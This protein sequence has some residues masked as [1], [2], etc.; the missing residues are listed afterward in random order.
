[1]IDAFGS[2]EFARVRVGI[3]RP[4]TKEEVTGYV[5]SQ[6][7]AQQRATLDKVITMAQNAVETI[8]VKGLT[9]G[10]NRYSRKEIGLN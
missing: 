6:F 7:D 3:G 4:D 10:M 1:L 9:V 2:G 8:L 5:L